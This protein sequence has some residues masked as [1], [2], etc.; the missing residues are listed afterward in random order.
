MPHVLP[1]LHALARRRVAVYFWKEKKKD[2]HRKVCLVVWSHSKRADQTQRRC[3]RLPV[4][5]MPITSST[6][7][8]CGSLKRSSGLC[9]FFSWKER[10]VVC[11]TMKLVESEMTLSLNLFPL[12][13]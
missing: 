12:F 10:E 13:T 6:F 9:P 4:T 7:R 8:I 3:H 5:G 11:V 2:H 1:R